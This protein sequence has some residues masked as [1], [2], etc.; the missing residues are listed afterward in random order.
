[1]KV[2][3]LESIITVGDKWTAFQLENFGATSQ[4]QYA[5]IST[6]EKAL[7]KTKFYTPDATEFAGWL[8]CGLDAFRNN[9]RVANK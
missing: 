2:F 8:Q 3:L 4:P 7:V 5:I 9:K 1:M 6:D